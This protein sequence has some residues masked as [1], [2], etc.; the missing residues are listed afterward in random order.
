MSPPKGKQGTKGQK[1]IVEENAET[2]NFYRTMV[3]GATG[4]YLAVMFIFFEFFTFFNIVM[5]IISSVA[6]LGSLQFM[7]HMAKPTLGDKGQVVDS[8]IDLNM[9]GGIAE[10]LKD[11]IILTSG[12]QLLS[13]I[14]NYFWLLMLLAP[15]RALY[16][17]WVNIL[18]VYFFQEAPSQEMDEKKQKK[19]ER[20]MKR[21]Q[22]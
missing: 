18:S 5:F 15:G 4:I 21:Q 22:H 20:R 7:A 13:L 16:F 2:M 9:V 10:H 3:L 1:Q 6:Y 19:L 17:V 11:M 12:S 14:S 8:G